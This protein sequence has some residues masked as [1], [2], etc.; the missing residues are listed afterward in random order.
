MHRKFQVGCPCCCLLTEE[1]FIDTGWQS[2]YTAGESDAWSQ[3]G[4]R[5]SLT[6]D[7][8]TITS[9]TGATGIMWL[10]SLWADT[11]TFDHEDADTYT[12]GT[13]ELRVKVADADNYI[14]LRLA[15][16][17]LKPPSFA[18]P[19]YAWRWTMQL[20]ERVGGIET[21]LSDAI[22]YTRHVNATTQRPHFA[23]I[24]ICV[25]ERDKD[26]YYYSDDSL[27]VRSALWWDDPPDYGDTEGS[28]VAS[29]S[30]GLRGNTS[31]ATGF[32][33]KHG[34]YLNAGPIAEGIDAIRTYEHAD[35][36][37]FCDCGI[38]NHGSEPKQLRVTFESDGGMDGATVDLYFGKRPMI[39]ATLAI[40]EIV[41]GWYDEHAWVCGHGGK[42]DSPP[43]V[44]GAH[45]VLEASIDGS[46]NV[47]LSLYVTG[48]YPNVNLSGLSAYATINLGPLQSKYD[49]NDL[50]DG[51]VFTDFDNLALFADGTTTLTATV[52]LIES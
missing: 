12:Y 10:F 39:A 8:G 35:D 38:C 45:T 7:S 21:A 46:N 51:L 50:Y 23:H 43:I 16:S 24:A 22:T 2:K 26:G 9:D 6:N 36:C 18:V 15:W 49:C 1:H 14:F 29:D 48:N 17:E 34:V 44:Q 37:R 20:F 4:S 11:P 52:E 42:I 30:Y 32:G 40:Y 3:S 5:I 28:D 25:D 19:Q 47:I 27:E 13:Y 31:T 41:F 33:T